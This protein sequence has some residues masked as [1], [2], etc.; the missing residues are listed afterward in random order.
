MKMGW[1]SVLSHTDWRSPA[2]GVRGTFDA[3]PSK[4]FLLQ[5]SCTRNTSDKF[6]CGPLHKIHSPS[7]CYINFSTPF[8][9]QMLI[10]IDLQCGIVTNKQSLPGS[11]LPTPCVDVAEVS[12]SFVSGGHCLQ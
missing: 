6:S 10:T 11:C 3:Y 2:L 12:S 4:K 5:S 8:V 7:Y 9:C 1:C